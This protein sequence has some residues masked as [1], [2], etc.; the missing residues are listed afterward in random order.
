MKEYNSFGKI[1]TCRKEE[2]NGNWYYVMVWPEPESWDDKYLTIVMAHR[3]GSEMEY[4]H[5]GDVRSSDM[6]V[7]CRKEKKNRMERD[8]ARFVA[9]AV[10][11]AVCELEENQEEQES[12][13]TDILAAL[14]ANK[15]AHE[16]S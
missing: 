3:D 2:I 11:T 12:F 9:D 14:E 5:P 15:A 8:M 6:E 1:V 7:F 4:T 13:E 16:K 10:N